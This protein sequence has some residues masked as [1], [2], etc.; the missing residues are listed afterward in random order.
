MLVLTHDLVGKAQRGI[1]CVY[2]EFLAAGTCGVRR[3]CELLSSW[4]NFAFRRVGRLRRAGLTMAD[5]AISGRQN[6]RGAS[7]W[8]LARPIAD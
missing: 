2:R 6:F 7:S 3:R 8:W 5:P 1:S 4:P